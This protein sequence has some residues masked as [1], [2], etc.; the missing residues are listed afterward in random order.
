LQVSVRAV[1]KWVHL[2]LESRTPEAL[3][4]AKRCGRPRGF[5]ELTDRRILSALELKPHTLGYPAGS[6]TVATLAHY[7]NGRYGT[8]VSTHTLRRRLKEL[9]LRY[10]RPR[11]VYEEKAPALAQKKGQSCEG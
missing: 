4:P 2:F 1:Y 6:W 9:G 5:T 11:Y 3:V 8:S 7:L 10:K